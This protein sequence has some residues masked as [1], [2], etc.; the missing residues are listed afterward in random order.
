[1]RTLT[2]ILAAIGGLLIGMTLSYIY[3]VDLV[4]RNTT[5]KMFVFIPMWSFYEPTPFDYLLAITILLI[6]ALTFYWSTFR[7]LGLVSRW[8]SGPAA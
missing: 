6:S 1:M 8:T 4:A 3:L 2:K 5:M 7:I